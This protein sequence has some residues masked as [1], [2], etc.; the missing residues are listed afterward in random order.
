VD[1]LAGVLTI[2][3]QT[4]ETTVLDQLQDERGFAGARQTGHHD[5]GRLRVQQRVVYV[6]D[7]PLAAQKQRVRL[8]LGH[9]EEQRFQ[10]ELL[11]LLL[12]QL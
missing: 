1:R 12:L 7:Q 8:L 5:A 4:A 10:H 2:G 11:Q 6:L 9:L 3:F